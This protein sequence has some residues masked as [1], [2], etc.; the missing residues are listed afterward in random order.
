MEVE[1][2]AG[3][4]DLAGEHLPE[5]HP[6]GV[7][8]GGGGDGLAGD[9]LRGEVALRAPADLLGGDEGHPRHEASLPEVGDL[10]EVGEDDDVLGLEV[11]V[12]HPP[13]VLDGLGVGVLE[14]GGELREDGL[15]L[16]EAEALPLGRPQV[17]DLAEGQPLEVLHHQIGALAVEALLVEAHDVGVREPPGHPGLE[18]EGVALV[19]GLE[20]L[21]GDQLDRHLHLDLPV[22]GPV[23]HTHGPLADDRADLVAVAEAVPDLEGTGDVHGAIASGRLRRA[24]PASGP[25]GKRLPAGPALGG[26]VRHVAAA[27]V[28]QQGGRLPGIQARKGVEANSKLGA[29]TTRLTPRTAPGSAPGV[30]EPPLTPRGFIQGLDLSYGH[31]H[32]RRHHQLGHP[33]APVEGHRRLAEVHQEHLELAPVVAVDGARGV[34]HRDPV[35]VGEAAAGADLALVARGD[36]H[37]EAGRHPRPGPGGQGQGRLEVGVEIE[38]GALAGLV[39]GQRQRCAPPLPTRRILSGSGIRGVYHT[40]V[41][42]G[43]Q[44]R[45]RK[46][47]RTATLSRRRPLSPRP[48]RGHPLGD[49]PQSP[50]PQAS[51]RPP[52]HRRGGLLRP[53]RSPAPGPPRLAPRRSRRLLLPLRR[54]GPGV[55]RLMIRLVSLLAPLMVW[56]PWPFHRLSLDTR[57][58]ALAR[59]E[60]SVL[61]APILALKAMLCIVWYEHPDTA[62]AVGF[63]QTCLLEAP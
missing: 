21:G 56:R 37:G 51:P 34:E 59:L 33:V 42:R 20:E 39:P 43:P 53:V 41:A 46:A 29:A 26:P 7:E 15:D 28:A 50:P 52:R 8:V 12:G 31:L 17:D 9:H 40:R 32:H 16:P 25:G 61:S 48:G 22:E 18:A 44:A 5:E 19:L 45:G 60:D 2:P 13:H 54:P 35:A 1:P 27:A 3:V 10:Q 4:I 49:A 57:I 58:R 36:G 55:S 6:Q 30:P 63:H 14:G 62:A 24:R 38:P 47:T 23:D 11:P